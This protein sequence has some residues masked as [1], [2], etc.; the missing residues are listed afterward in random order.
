MCSS[1]LA[2]ELPGGGDISP[3]ITDVSRAEA[4]GNQFF[5]DND[6]VKSKRT[7]VTCVFSGLPAI[8][9]FRAEMSGL[10]AFRTF[11]PIRSRAGLQ[12]VWNPGYSPEILF[13]SACPISLDHLGVS[14]S[15]PRHVHT[16]ALRTPST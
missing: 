2:V 6:L 5:Q 8:R 12:N 10:S 13:Q 9:K 7:V 1:D 16:R 11:R 15:N 14:P 4:A 3:G